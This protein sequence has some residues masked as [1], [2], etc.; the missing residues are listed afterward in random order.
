[1]VG[2][3]RSL[4]A[5]AIRFLLWLRYDIQVTG[6][7]T[8]RQRRGV[9]I[10]PN[11][12]G[13]M[14]P[15][16][17]AT[18]LWGR[19]HPHPVVIEDFYFMPAVNQLMRFIGAIP[20]PNMDGGAG[21]Y[22]RLRVEQSLDQVVERLCAGDNVLL[23][24]A[25]R[26]MR[27]GLEDLRGA[28]AVAEI[29]SREPGVPIL[30]ARST[31][32]IGSSFSWVSQRRRP[33][34]LGCFRQG[35]RYLLENLIV[36]SPRRPCRIHLEFAPEDLP[37]G[38]DKNALNRWL[39]EWYNRD[40]E[41]QPEPVSYSRWRRVHLEIEQAKT[42]EQA[43]T[44]DV[45]PEVRDKTMAEIARM[46]GRPPA[47]L[48][49][50]MNLS[51]DLDMDSLA[52]A[53]LAAWLEEE[54]YVTDVD[55]ADLSSVGAVLAA[56]VGQVGEREDATPARLP[57]GWIE[58]APRPE[59]LIPDPDQPIHLNFL[60]ACDRLAGAIAVG[61]ETSGAL[62]FKAAKVRAVALAQA[63]G[64]IPEK[65]VGIMLPASAGANLVIMA[66]LLAGKVP[67]MINWTV[68]DANLKHVLQLSEIKTIITSG[69][70]LDRLEQI[71]F[72]LIKEHILTLE[73]VRAQRL[74]LRAQLRAWFLARRAPETICR[75]LGSDSVQADQTAVILFTSGSESAP[76]GVPL[77]HRNILANVAGAI[78]S[79]VIEPGEVLFAF[80]PP[81]HS[82]GFTVTTV[83]PMVSGLKT[84]YYPNPTDSRRLGAGI[85]MWRPTMI[86]GTPTFVAGILRAA[87]DE[88]LESLRLIVC[89]AEKTPDELAETAQQRLGAEIL[90]GYGITET[91]P[92]LT[93]NRRG[94]PRVGVGQP[95]GDVKLRIVDPESREPLP[96]GQRG[97][98]LAAGSNVFG[99]YLGRD[100]AD[101][102]AE[103]DGEQWYITG[104]LG[105]LDEAGNLI[106]A[107]RLKRFVKV[108][109][110][111]IS[112]P[113]MEEA[114]R[115][116]HP[117]EDGEPRSAIAYVD[118]D[119]QRP[120]LCLYAVFSATVE[121]VNGILRE[122]GF[123]NLA[124][125]AR[126]EA[127]DEM[128]VLGT[129]KTDYRSLTAMLQ[130]SLAAEA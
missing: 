67:V 25:G 20:M 46:S 124:R 58:T 47:D 35:A 76:K 27:S 126:V 64:D 120:V 30:L 113:A 45:P 31:G 9:L 90:E 37:R 32:L 39:E 26:L 109:G 13:E 16:I 10:L 106:L 34:L 75:A 91:A 114:I 116:V 7:E 88:Q 117:N 5:A 33:D 87:R 122:A 84:A 41:E 2:I 77:S 123:S 82:F 19:L 71:D 80:L 115:Q 36:F 14:D 68:G 22:K 98:I 65:N 111:M 42:V 28:S 59:S 128:P 40:G 50:E 62:S 44:A 4:L 8:I 43:L 89:G 127:L 107:G 78:E 51:R 130:T 94:E 112:L 100:S 15:V 49:P 21:A 85:A 102:F 99:G 69:R 119:G 24:P 110:E 72:N 92:V 6:L 66:T 81:F 70:F 83:L 29:L 23:Y 93:M 61:D 104:D 74:T 86:C 53:D 101:A 1:M 121:E 3:C 118:Q 63:L 108:G 12:P 57:S 60:R 79:G 97:L 54:F 38:A 95:V 96:L 55:A 52:L 18:K 105:Y 129:G 11:H 17:L 48:T 56:A 125:V 73:D 103:I